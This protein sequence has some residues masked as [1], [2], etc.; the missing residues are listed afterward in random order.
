MYWEGSIHMR[1]HLALFNLCSSI[2]IGRLVFD[3]Y[4]AAQNQIL[5]KSFPEISFGNSAIIHP[6]DM[7]R[8]IR[9]GDTVFWFEFTCGQWALWKGMD[10]SF[11][12]PQSAQ[13]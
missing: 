9:G 1:F 4:W 8:A 3:Q 11:A 7:A 12:S 6:N 10:N 2:F 5:P 13:Q